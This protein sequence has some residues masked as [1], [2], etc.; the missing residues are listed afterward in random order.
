MDRV[1]LVFLVFNVLLCGLLIIAMYFIHKRLE[2]KEWLDPD[3][4]Y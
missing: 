3:N 4:D 1:A 2:N